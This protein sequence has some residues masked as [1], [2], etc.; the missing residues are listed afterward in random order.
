M[1]VE[2]AS[3]LCVRVCVRWRVVGFRVVMIL[4]GSV[5]YSNTFIDRKHRGKTFHNPSFPSGRFLIY[6]YLSPSCCL[7]FSLSLSLTHFFFS[8]SL[9]NWTHVLVF[10]C[11]LHTRQSC[12][13]CSRS[14]PHWDTG[15]LFV[16]SCRFVWHTL[17]PKKAHTPN[18]L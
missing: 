18:A 15:H 8:L 4:S 16:R 2:F 14:R 6:L 7:S 13:A 17:T 1:W 5:L 3:L 11:K 9:S 10:V 12:D